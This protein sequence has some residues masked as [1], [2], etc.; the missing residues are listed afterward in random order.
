MLEGAEVIR[1]FARHLHQSN[2]AETSIR[3]EQGPSTKRLDSH[4]LAVS[5]LNNFR[6][7]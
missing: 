3:F 6:T 2:V 4:T 7:F 1:E 5:T